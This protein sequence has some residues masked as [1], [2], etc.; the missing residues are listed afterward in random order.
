M[1]LERSDD[2][3]P[4]TAYGT[5]GLSLYAAIGDT[6][7]RGMYQHGDDFYVVHRGTFYKVDGTGGG[8]H[9]KGTLLTTSGRVDMAHNTTQIII[10]DGANGYIYTIA[11]EA[12]AQI[13]HGDWP[14]ADTVAF[15]DSFFIVNKP[16]TGQFYLSASYDGATWDAAM[17]ATAESAPDNLVRVF[18]DHGELI[19]FGDTTTEFWANTGALD[20]PYSKSGPTQEAGLAARW[21]VAR[22]DNSLIWLAKNRM[23]E[24]QVVR[25]NGYQ[26]QRVSTF[27]IENIFNSYSTVLDATGFSYLHNGHPFY[28]INF[29]TA[30]ESW[31][32]D[33]AM[34]CWSQL[35]YGVSGRHRSEISVCFASDVKVSDYENGNIYT[36]SG[37]VYTDNGAPIY[38]ELT[39]KHVFNGGERTSI[40][41]L[42]LDCE[43]GVGTATGQGSNPQVMLQ[44]SKDGGHNWGPERW[45]SLGAI[46][47]YTAR[48]I[49]HRLGMAK[50]DWT[51]KI[52]ISD[53]IKRV[54]TGAW[55]NGG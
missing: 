10:V 23:G 52:R 47:N 41:D 8:F 24:A 31:L 46:G 17:F 1:Y 18:V 13:T 3:G 4:V 32:Y 25:L 14:G 53:P 33:G 12:F 44:V 40:S 54:I 42:W 55:I 43:T 29:S 34:D 51:F 45:A 9:G 50:R 35:K 21:S 15:N 7:V 49:W 16:S 30:G 5:P 48:A 22:F 36:V 38:S 11:S 26:L 20:F 39:G 6:P 27:D 37:D 19:L 2:K 28:Q